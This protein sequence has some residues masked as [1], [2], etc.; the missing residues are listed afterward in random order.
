MEEDWDYY[1]L[2]PTSISKAPNVDFVSSHNFGG[3]ISYV[4]IS[5]TWSFRSIQ[6]LGETILL[7]C[8]P[9]N[10]WYSSS[11]MWS[12]MEFSELNIQYFGQYVH[13]YSISLLSQVRA[14]TKHAL[15]RPGRKRS[16]FTV[17]EAIF[18]SS[19]QSK[20]QRGTSVAPSVRRSC[21]WLSV[22]EREQLGC[23]EHWYPLVIQHSYWTWL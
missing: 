3:E 2:I 23:F 20:R 9:N 21:Q 4:S 13:N 8:S 6:Q 18:T 7:E 14:R 19:W 12:K 17:T 16:H 22:P 15:R 11:W 5:L 10:T 1:I